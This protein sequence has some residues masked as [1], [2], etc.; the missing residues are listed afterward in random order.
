MLNLKIRDIKKRKNFKKFEKKKKILKALIYNKSINK[1]EKKIIFSKFYNIPIN[2]SKIRI[3]KRC[4]LTNRPK[5]ILSFFKISR[6]KFRELASKGNLP[7]L[8][9]YTN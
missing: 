7:F 4:I 6:I 1:K 9:K 8:K 2:S 3:K 5:G